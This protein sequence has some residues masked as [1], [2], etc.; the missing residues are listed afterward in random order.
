MKNIITSLLVLTSLFSY[1]QNAALDP[2]F[3]NAGYSVHPSPYTAEINCFAFDNDSNIISAGYANQGGSGTYNYRLTLTKTDSD[4]ILDTNFGNNGMATTQI[5]YSE[6]PIQ[7]A[8]QP[9]GKIIVV[10]ETNLGPT[11][12]SPGTYI[13]FAVRYNSDGSLDTSFATNGIYKLPSSR[14]FNSIILLSDGSIILGGSTNTD[15]FLVKLDSNGVEDSLFG[16]NGVLFLSSTSFPFTLSRATLL[17]DGK[18]LCIGNNSDI[19]N[20]KAAYCKLDIQGNFDT[21]FGTNG[22]VVE[23]LFNGVIYTFE[24]LRNA[25]ELSDGTIVIEGGLVGST[26][27]NFLFKIN[28]DGSF[29]NSFGNNGIIYH[30]YPT[31]G[32]FEI[33]PNDKI[34]IAGTKMIGTGNLAYSVTRLD[35][36]G[37]LDTTFNNGNGFVD[38][39]ATPEDDYV[40]YIKSQAPDTLII[41]GASKLNTMNVGNFTL[42]RV[43]LN[44]PLSIEEPLEQNIKIYP[45]PFKEQ[46]VIEDAEQIIEEIKIFDN[47]GRMIKAISNPTPVQEIHADFSS[48]I[49]YIN[50]MAKDGRIMNKKMI[51]N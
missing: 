46:F 26:I 38:V 37:S 41:G 45:N 4:G 18:I 22:K 24:V 12:I 32:G 6:A 34:L 2:V 33:Q 1:A 11:P 39:D 49:Y 21:A 35:S 13:G 8:I 10:G 19:I 3:G 16:T 31:Q 23:D 50:I 9:D 51:K 14:L 42:A 20:S 44:T 5:E 7:I 17:S 30:S 48:G 36:D 28:S 40:H 43:L 29:D 15:G 25:D 27:S 47:T